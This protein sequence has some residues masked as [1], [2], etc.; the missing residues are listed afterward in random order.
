MPD[1][2]LQPREILLADGRLPSPPPEPQWVAPFLRVLRETA[3]VR[4]CADAAGIDRRTAYY[5]RDND[6]DFRAAWDDCLEDACDV[7]EAKARERALAGLSDN[8]LMFLLKAHRPRVYRETTRP[9]NKF[10]DMSDEELL[11]WLRA[12]FESPEGPADHPLSIRRVDP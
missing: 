11:D 4:A 7:L 8:L 6:P 1:N 10:E 2:G 3:N 12:Q 9:A 5:R